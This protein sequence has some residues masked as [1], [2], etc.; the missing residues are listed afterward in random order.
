MQYLPFSPRGYQPIS[1][2][3]ILFGSLSSILEGQTGDGGYVTVLDRELHLIK[4]AD[5]FV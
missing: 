1:G 5:F 2:H 3:R 4:C